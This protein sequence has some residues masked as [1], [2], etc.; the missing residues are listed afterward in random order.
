MCKARRRAEVIAGNIAN[1]DTQI[2][3]P[4]EFDDLSKRSR[5][6]N[7]SPQ[8]QQNHLEPK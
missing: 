5:T 4:P 8:T 7:L 2:T 3:L 1:A 6:T